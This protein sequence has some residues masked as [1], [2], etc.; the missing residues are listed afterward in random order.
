MHRSRWLTLFSCLA[1]LQVCAAC[2]PALVDAPG[3]ALLTLSPVDADVWA[4]QIAVTGEITGKFDAQRCEFNVG[5]AAW[6]A[7]LEGSRFSAVVPL[8]PGPNRVRG[9]CFDAQG[10]A[11][12]SQEVSYSKRT[13]REFQNPRNSAPATMSWLDD[14]VL[15]GILPPLYG[16]P[17]LKAATDI[18]PALAEL[19]ATAIWLSPI[20]ATPPGNFGYAVTDYF[21][22]RKDYGTA[23]ELRAFVD[24]AHALGLH[25]IFDFVP[26]HTSDK[27]PYF[28]QAKHYGERS[29]YFHFYMRDPNGKSEHYF[30][31]QDLPNLDYANSEVRAFITA[32]SQSWLEAFGNDGYRVDAAW[33]IAQRQ[34]NF[35][36]PW[37][38]SVRAVQPN[39]VLI[40]EASARDPFYEKN[41]FDAAYDWTEELGHWAWAQ[42]FASNEG[43]APQL[44]RALET[45]ARTH[46]R[47]HRVVRFLNNNDTGPRFV[48][49]LLL[50]LPGIPCLYSLDEIGGEFEPYASLGPFAGTTHP[51]L[52][53]LHRMLIRLRRQVSALHGP[54]FELLEVTNDP[55]VLA[56]L[57]SNRDG[58]ERALVLINFSSLPQSVRLQQALP[59]RGKLLKNLAESG[60]LVRSPDI[61]PLALAPF[62]YAIVAD[63]APD[64]GVRH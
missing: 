19:G 21:T 20:M 3:S 16:K 41:G 13:F 57:R 48:T 15:Y 31:W 36:V 44:H 27:H 40:A 9:R 6:P 56:Y 11:I 61:A 39:A 4:E 22:V 51:E 58:S 46:A 63:R 34:P 30:D 47:L 32:A 54:G 38:Q 42:A 64:P 49:V 45:A 2:H 62:G 28:E 7:R 52:R 18:L 59:F 35:Y 29:H 5:Q 14:T 43:V 25:V 26:N 37:A 23:E 24:R 33:G 8:M 17:P 53:E 10:R 50:T 60:A 55:D 1:A 12:D